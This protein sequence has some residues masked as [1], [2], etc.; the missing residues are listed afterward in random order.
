MIPGSLANMM[1]SAEASPAT[2]AFVEAR[3]D[4]GGTSPWTFSGMS[5]GAAASDRFVIVAV[6]A[7]STS[8][9]AP[10]CITAVTIAGVSATQLAN[11]E[12]SNG[13]HVYDFWGASVP[14][15]TTGDVVVTSSSGRASMSVAVYRAIGLQ[16]TTPTATASDNTASADVLSAG[17]TVQS[18]G[19]AVAM[20]GIQ[21]GSATCTWGGSGMTEDA[22]SP[23]PVDP[24]TNSRQTCA[25]GNY[26]SGGSPTVTAD[27]SATNAS[28]ALLVMAMR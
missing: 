28:E 3:G 4:Q 24:A 16:S 7:P 20:S 6:Y 8:T 26:T 15:G 11:V 12:T 17:I 1:M 9:N 19:F 13:Y 23:F 14:T 25:S 21:H 10:D 27:W 2:V 18:G 5:I 22:D